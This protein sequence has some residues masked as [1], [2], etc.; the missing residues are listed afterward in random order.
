MNETAALAD[1]RE[2]APQLGPLML[3]DAE[4]GPVA[5]TVDDPGELAA[6]IARLVQAARGLRPG[7]GRGVERLHVT[8][9]EG[10]VFAVSRGGRMLV[11]LG[12]TDAAPALVF[13]DLR[14]TL[15]RLENDAPA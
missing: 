7:S 10:A 8:T 12:P 15:D 5:S 4:G 9:G 11:A 1:L 13:H 2:I 3:L 6:A 14:T